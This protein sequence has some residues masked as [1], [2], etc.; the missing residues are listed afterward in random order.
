[1]GYSQRGHKESDI[2]EQLGTQ[3]T[4]ASF[5]SP[6]VDNWSFILQSENMTWNFLLLP[7]LFAT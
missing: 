5:N 3:H 6:Q 7:H 1:M 2:T 4:R